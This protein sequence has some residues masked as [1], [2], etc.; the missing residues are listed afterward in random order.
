VL[1]LAN[2]ILSEHREFGRGVGD[3]I[4]GGV[5]SFGAQEVA[6][7]FVRAEWLRPVTSAIFQSPMLVPIATAQASQANGFVLDRD[8]YLHQSPR[9]Q[10]V[11]SS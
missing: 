6:C 9:S 1:H 4:I 5:Q 7:V 2:V 3:G 11:A 10:L 8:L